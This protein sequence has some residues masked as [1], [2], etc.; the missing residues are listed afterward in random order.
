VY[1]AVHLLTFTELPGR[2]SFADLVDVE[3][4]NAGGGAPT[5]AAF[6]RDWKELRTASHLGSACQR[7][8]TLA[9]SLATGEP[10]DFAENVSGL[11]HAHARR[12]IEAIAIATGQGEMYAITPTPALDEMLARRD[13]LLS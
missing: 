3:D 8:L 9:A 2:A 7:L 1:A 13:A 4:I 12:V 10:V 5:L 6:V 11:G